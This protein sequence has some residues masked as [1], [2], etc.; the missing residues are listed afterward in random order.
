MW[1][2]SVACARVRLGQGGLDCAYKRGCGG[3]LGPEK[4][5]EGSLGMPNTSDVGCECGLCEG[6]DGIGRAIMCIRERLW[7]ASR[8]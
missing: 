3:P 7:G 8:A 4:G 1:A 6:A 2:V 5:F